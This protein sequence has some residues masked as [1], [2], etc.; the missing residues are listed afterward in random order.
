[1]QKTCQFMLKLSNIGQS[2][3]G[4]SSEGKKN[5]IS[6]MVYCRIKLPQL[7]IALSPEGIPYIVLLSRLNC[8][9]IFVAFY[10][11]NFRFSNFVEF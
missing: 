8:L 2:F 11:Y 3:I 1:M 5:K 4:L 7:I 10:H 9:S 6:F